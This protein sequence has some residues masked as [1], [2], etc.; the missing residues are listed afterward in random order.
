MFYFCLS[1][2]TVISFFEQKL[3]SFKAS[4]TFALPNPYESL[5]IIRAFV[6]TSQLSDIKVE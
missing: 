5:I 2:S 1:I 3:Q 4:L 6:L